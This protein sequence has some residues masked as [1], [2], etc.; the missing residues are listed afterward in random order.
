[1]AVYLGV[2]GGLFAKALLGGEGGLTPVAVLWALSA[3]PAL[4]VLTAVLTMR[5]VADERTTGR[6]ELMQSVAVRP[7]EIVLGKFLGAW[8]HAALALTLYLAVPLMLLP[9]CAPALSAHLTWD[10]FLPAYGALLMQAALW[11]ACG[12]LSSVCFRP[13]AVA[14]IVSIVL[15]VVLPSAAYQAAFTWVRAFRMRFSE[16]PFTGHLVDLSTGLVQFSTIFFYFALT[17]CALFAASKA[18]ALL[19]LA[20]RGWRGAR[21]W[22]VRSQPGSC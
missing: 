21:L 11:C 22:H 16:Q 18:L 4:P 12:L 3:A 7:R 10:V 5:L 17:V 14:A 20:G 13:A 9:P 15:T 6:L 19:R 1:V 2:S 8:L